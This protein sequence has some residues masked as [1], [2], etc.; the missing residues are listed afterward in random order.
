MI[1]PN[2]EERIAIA[3]LRRLA[4]KWPKSL[5]LFAGGGGLAVMRADH[6]AIDPAFFITTV[7][8][9]SDGGDW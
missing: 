5:W 1:I 4:K 9:P 8:I 3:A 2:A 6:E 7:N